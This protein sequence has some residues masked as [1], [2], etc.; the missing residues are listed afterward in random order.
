MTKA[1]DLADNALGSKPKVVDAKGDLMVASTADTVV[2]VTIG[3][4]G[5][6]LKADSATTSGVSWATVDALPSQ[7][8]NS[9]KYLTTNGSTASWTT[10][11]TDPTTDIFLLMGA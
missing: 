3:T 8:G 5:Q 11:T 4:N 6:F 9:G 10:I 7:S 2:A 1:R